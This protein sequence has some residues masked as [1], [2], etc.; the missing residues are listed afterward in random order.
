MAFLVPE[1]VGLMTLHPVSLKTM[2]DALLLLWKRAWFQ[3]LSLG[4]G[5]AT[6]AL[7]LT[8]PLVLHLDT[9]LLGFPSIDAQDTVTL[10]GQIASMLL[11]P[12][13]WPIVMKK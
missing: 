8:W 4:L 2:R 7:V 6:A 11:Q 5:Y 13:A 12:S 3:S 10:R 9:A 1:T